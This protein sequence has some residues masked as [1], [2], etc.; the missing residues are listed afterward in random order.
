M[1]GKPSSLS[2]FL[3]TIHQDAKWVV[4]NMEVCG[5][6]QTWAL[7]NQHMLYGVSDGSFKDKFGTAAYVIG[8][9]DKPQ[10]YMRGRVVTP[11]NPEEQNAF[12]SELAGIYAITVMH[13]AVCEFFKLEQG[14]IKLACNRKSALHQAQ[15]PEDFI[16]TQYP[17]YDMILA[18]RS[19][20]QRTNWNWLWRH[21]KGHQDDTGIV[22]DCWAQANIQMDSTAKQHWA[23]TQNSVVPSLKIWGKPRQVWV[24]PR[25]I[26]SSLSRTLQNFCSEQS[27]E[28]YWR[29][30]PRI[31]ERFDS[32]DWEAIRG[33]MKAAPLN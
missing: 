27:A 31:G 24:G 23:E 12:R 30:K 17:H 7:S 4:E 10:I 22:L 13:W 3:S 25:K 18:I 16:N 2:Q 5:D 8:V 29:A 15:W 11:G 9:V 32:V 21:V 1:Q 6:W 33:A 26:T 14:Q 28:K 20:R 19:I